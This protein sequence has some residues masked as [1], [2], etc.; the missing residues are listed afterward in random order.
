MVPNN[1][2]PSGSYNTVI[3]ITGSLMFTNN[4]VHARH[5]PKCH[6]RHISFTLRHGLGKH[7]RIELSMVMEC[8]RT[9]I[10]NMAATNH[11]WL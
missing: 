11:M 5:C 1:N 2:V 8:S 9:A 3:I 10:S 4:L 7:C 6:V